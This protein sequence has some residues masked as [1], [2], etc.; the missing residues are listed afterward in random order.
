MA[1]PTAKVATM[2]DFRQVP[3]AGLVDATRHEP[4]FGFMSTRCAGTAVV[5]NPFIP[6]RLL[7]RFR[8]GVTCW[9]TGAGLH[10]ARDGPPCR[11]SLAPLSARRSHA[12]RPRAQNTL[13]AR[14]INHVILYMTGTRL[15]SLALHGRR[16]IKVVRLVRLV[17]RSDRLDLIAPSVPALVVQQMVR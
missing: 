7:T 15:T 12:I 2:A 16:F 17:S 13:C 3:G 5:P 8:R 11:S 14:S 6:R 10:R 1:E 9:Q 4:I